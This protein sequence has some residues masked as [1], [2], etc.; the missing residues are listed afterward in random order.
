MRANYSTRRSSVV[1]N[2][3][4]RVLGGLGDSDGG[5]YDG[6]GYDGGG[7]AGDGGGSSDSFSTGYDGS[8]A[9]PG[10]GG[11]VSFSTGIGGDGPPGGGDVAE[12]SIAPT[13]AE[14]A[15]EAASQAAANATAAAAASAAYSQQQMAYEAVSL[16]AANAAAFEAS[17]MANEAALSAAASALAASRASNAQSAKVAATIATGAMS[18]FGPI[19]VIAGLVAKATGFVDR[20]FENAMNGQQ[21]SYDKNIS[22]AG[23]ALEGARGYGGD[24]AAINIEINKVQANLDAAKNA[25]LKA[26]ITQLYR[27]YAKRE[28]DPAGLAYWSNA[29]G[30]T[31]TADEVLAFQESL[32]INEPNLRPVAV[33]TQTAA[34]P[35]NN[36]ALPIIAAVAGFLIFGS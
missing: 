18:L 15:F 32:Y 12:G 7:N 11:S 35:S 31:V 28:P 30:P 34:Q 23:A 5:G 9:D 29:F 26:A 33:T 17:Q 24:N 36:L 14:A 4:G 13:A 6:G 27:T 16:A 22:D 10:E 19:G 20:A 2:P 25:G 3:R 21:L 8:S 1:L